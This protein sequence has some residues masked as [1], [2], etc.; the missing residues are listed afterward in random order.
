MYHVLLP[1]DDSKKRANAQAR[2]ITALPSCEDIFVTLLHVYEDWDQTEEVPD[3]P[4]VGMVGDILSDCR[5]ETDR[6]FGEPSEEIVRVAEEIDAD[7]I[8]LGGRKRSP[9]GSLLFGSV[10]QSV[11]LHADR[12][13][14]ITGDTVKS[15][16]TFSP[17]GYAGGE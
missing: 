14:M 5:V 10:S 17:P 6:A 13:V 16:E 8:V 7:A 12:P 15:E 2:A 9:L 11:M 4:S 1:I 3:L